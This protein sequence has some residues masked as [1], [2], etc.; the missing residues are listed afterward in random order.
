MNKPELLDL[1]VNTPDGRGSIL[2]LY[3]KGVV[4]C[5]NTIA[6][7]QEMQGRKHGGEMHY[8]YPYDQ[9]EIIKGQCNFTTRSTKNQS[10]Q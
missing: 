2:V 9:V 7:R 10:D 4:V 5:L 6:C 1:E 8:F 3:P